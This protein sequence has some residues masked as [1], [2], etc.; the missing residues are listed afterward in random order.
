[1]RTK[2]YGTGIGRAIWTE[3]AYYPGTASEKR[4]KIPPRRNIKIAFIAIRRFQLFFTALRKKYTQ[5]ADFVKWQL[6]QPFYLFEY[7]IYNIKIFSGVFAFPQADILILLC[8]G[9]LMLFFFFILRARVISYP[10]MHFRLVN[11]LIDSNNLRNCFRLH[12]NFIITNNKIPITFTMN[13]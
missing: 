8:D 10:E 13:K 5:R 9:F 11:Y 7:S 12:Q 2:R 3:R 1:M 6:S 4:A